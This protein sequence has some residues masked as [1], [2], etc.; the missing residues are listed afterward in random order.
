MKTD[1][2]TAKSDNITGMVRHQG[3]ASSMLLHVSHVTEVENGQ[4]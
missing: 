4:E 3:Y 2:F 1:T